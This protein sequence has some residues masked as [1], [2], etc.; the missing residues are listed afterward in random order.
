MQIRDIMERSDNMHATLRMIVHEATTT[1]VATGVPGYNYQ[2][3]ESAQQWVLF[4][5]PSGTEYAPPVLDPSMMCI[6]V[7]VPQHVDGSAL[8]ASASDGHDE[9]AYLAWRNDL[10]VIEIFGT[11]IDKMRELETSLLAMIASQP[12]PVVPKMRRLMPPH[13]RRT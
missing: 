13:V 7:A 2:W 8:V 4:Y 3:F 10:R 11:V 9:I 12:Q 1:R 6:T 5:E